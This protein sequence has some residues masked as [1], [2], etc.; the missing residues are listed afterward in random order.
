[1]F[2]LSFSEDVFDGALAPFDPD[3][4]KWGDDIPDFPEVFEHKKPE[5]TTAPRERWRFREI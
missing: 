1:M 4:E 2:V 3:E 5:T